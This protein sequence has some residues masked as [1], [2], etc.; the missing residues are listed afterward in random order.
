MPRRRSRLVAPAAVATALLALGS[1]ALLRGG[2]PRPTLGHGELLGVDVSRHQGTI[3][4]E[5]VARDGIRFAY[6]KATEGGDFVDDHFASNWQAAADAGLDRGAYH[7]FTLC[8]A[9]ADQADNFLRTVP[10]DARALPPAVDLELVGNCAGRPPREALL[11]ELEAFV[12][13]VEAAIGKKLV[14]YVLRDFEVEYRILA[15]LDR[16]R[17]VPSL[18]RR[19]EAH[20][21]RLWQVA[22]DAHVAGIE[23]SVDLDVMKDD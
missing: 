22:S 11:V 5:R 23:G 9:G 10:R 8:R 19:P 15:A 6:L 17:W 20:D 3:D 1:F 18:Q 4:W 7:F 12:D 14:V 2:R 16:P 13:K 21:W